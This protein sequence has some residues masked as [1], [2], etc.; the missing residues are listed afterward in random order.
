MEQTGGYNDG[1]SNV[2]K[3]TKSI[4]GSK[5]AAAIWYTTLKKLLASLH[6][7]GSNNDSCFLVKMTGDDNADGPKWIF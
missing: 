4:Y 6:Y 3:F 7:E 1:T 2:C 5:Q